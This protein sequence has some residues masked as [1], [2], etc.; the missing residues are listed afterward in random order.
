MLAVRCSSCAIVP[1]P[2]TFRAC[3]LYASP[4]QI[5]AIVPFTVTPSTGSV[6]TE[7]IPV[8]IEI[9]NPG[10]AAVVTSSAT[11]VLSQPGIFEIGGGGLIVNQDGTINGPANPAKQGSV[12]S[13]FVTGLGPL[14]QTPADGSFATAVSTPTL[15]IQVFLGLGAADSYV[16]LNPASI[17]YVGDAPGEIEGLQQ[18]NLVLPAGIVF[19]TRRHP[20]A[21]LRV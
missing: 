20:V 3:N 11:P 4:N 1:R 17:T 10:N 7:D 21:A 18:I 13:L 16:P 12:I 9:Q 5:N 2:T 14:S 6:A 19:N 8:S 15:P